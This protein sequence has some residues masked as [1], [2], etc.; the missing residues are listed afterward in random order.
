M[1]GDK[2]ERPHPNSPQQTST[3]QPW[4]R[5]WPGAELSGR[6]TLCRSLKS[7]PAIPRSVPRPPAC[8][9]FAG[10][11]PCARPVWSPQGS[12]GE[13][14]SAGIRGNH[15]Q[16]HKHTHTNRHPAPPHWEPKGGPASAGAPLNLGPEQA[17]ARREQLVQ[18]GWWVGAVC[19][20]ALAGLRWGDGVHSKARLPGQGLP[21]HVPC[22]QQGLGHLSPRTTWG[23]CLRDQVGQDNVFAAL[24]PVSYSWSASRP[25]EPSPYKPAHR[26][27]KFRPLV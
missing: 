15:G 2:G 22:H 26:P 6:V 27:C 5:P 20:K 1:Q 25:K 24:L 7:S 23:R 3:R 21:A 17:T 4:G 9:P 16:S 19:R 14:T 18:S 8:T 13:Q 11:P 12:S 10:C